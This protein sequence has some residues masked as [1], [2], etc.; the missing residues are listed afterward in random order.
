M[1][2]KP[3]VTFIAKKLHQYYR[4]KKDEIKALKQLQAYFPNL[5]SD[6]TCS[7]ILF[8]P[9]SPAANLTNKKRRPIKD[10]AAAK[11]IH[12]KTEKAYASSLLL[13]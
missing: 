4:K 10:D 2:S 11:I 12:L 5:S 8:C 1:F 7:G 9:S 13:C 3:A 6:A